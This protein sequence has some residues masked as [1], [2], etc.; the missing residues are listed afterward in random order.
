M[1]SSRTIPCPVCAREHAADLFDLDGAEPRAV[2]VMVIAEDFPGWRCARGHRLADAAVVKRVPYVDPGPIPVNV[3]AYIAGHPALR[4]PV[5]GIPIVLSES[6]PPR[7]L[8]K[9]IGKAAQ[10]P[11]NGR[12][13][14]QAFGA[15]ARL[16]DVVRF[17]SPRE[18]WG[19]IDVLAS[20]L[21]A[22][23]TWH[24]VQ[25]DGGESKLVPERSIDVMWPLD[26]SDDGETR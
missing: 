18:T 3:D 9:A 16:G 24:A 17:Y 19:T 15:K 22:T 10:R 12:W 7:R 23:E 2:P 25:T 4:G 20:L 21:V 13:Y 11:S 6:K 8:T 26:G 5:P 1:T 14:A